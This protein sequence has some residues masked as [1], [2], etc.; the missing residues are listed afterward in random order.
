M[1][2]GY[3]D[4]F[5]T[6]PLP[7]RA[8]LDVADDDSKSIPVSDHGGQSIKNRCHVQIAVDGSFVVWDRL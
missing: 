6:L 2:G 1:C 8:S 3:N 4:I 7:T 5:L